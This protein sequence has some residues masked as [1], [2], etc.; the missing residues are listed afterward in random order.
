MD[1][2]EVNLQ[3][4]GYLNTPNLWLGNLVYNLQQLEVARQPATRFSET[5][6]KNIRL[7]KRVEQFVFHHLKQLPQTTILCQNLQIQQERHTLGEMD[8]L[9]LIN[10]KP[11]HLEII[12]KFYVY[13]A[14]GTNE[15]DHWIGP[16]R[17]DSLVQK[18]DKLKNKQLPLLYHPETLK[19]LEK[20]N[21]K[22]D[23]IKQQ[24]LFMAQLF[25]PYNQTLPNFKWINP[26]CI[27]GY[28][29]KKEELSQFKTC[30]FYLPTKANWLLEP[31]AQVAWLTHPAC[32]E[33]LTPILDNQTAPL[34]W[35]KHPNGEIS[36]SF[37]LWW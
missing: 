20:H 5:L 19:Y 24:V 1:N 29:L 12:Y 11:V 22:V 28:Y 18:L 2:K 10:N 16:N 21:L 33:L 14:M 17:K 30:K 34:I 3:Y 8:A 7:G 13:D 15:L 6:P 37:I 36:K 26:A 23:Q 31:H 4:L 25:V 32:K 9:L 35:I 27:R